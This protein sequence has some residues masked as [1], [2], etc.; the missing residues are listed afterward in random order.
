[1]TTSADPTEEVVALINQF[2][3]EQ[4]LPALP[5]DPRLARA[6]QR[7]SE[8]MATNDFFDHI[9]SDGSDPWQRMRDAGYPLDWGAECIAAGHPDAQSVLEAWL[10]S[11]E[12]RE[13]LLG[14]FV[15]IGAGFVE[16]PASTYGFYWTV[17]LAVPL[18]AT[19]APTSTAFWSPTPV[20][21]ST[22][23]TP[24]PTSTPRPPTPTPTGTAIIQVNPSPTYTWTP[25][26]PTPTASPFPY[27]G[28][29]TPFPTIPV[30]TSTSTPI[31]YVSPTPRP[32]S[33]TG[34]SASEVY[35]P[36]LFK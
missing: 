16:N 3:V 27:P 1:M 5:L 2:R 30:A 34:Q 8:D 36:L 24:T 22:A 20:A 29:G 6:A 19:V 7:H 17:N 15:H 4:G 13:I 28:P 23:V 31:G 11:T 14:H 10:E 35:L 32:T 9:G 26:P 18:P 33:A 12:H 21:T 25:R